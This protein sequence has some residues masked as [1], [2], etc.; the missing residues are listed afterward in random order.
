[1][2]MSTLLIE[3]MQP[4]DWPAVRSIYLEGIAT[5]HATFETEAPSWEDWD[6]SHHRFGRLV[7]RE[8]EGV[9]GWAALTLVSRRQVYA[10]VAEVSVY[11]AGDSRGKGVGSALLKR[12]ICESEQNGIWTLQASVFPEN[13]ATIGLHRACGFREVGRRERIGKLRGVWRDTLLLERRSRVAGI[14]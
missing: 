6:A 3:A 10:G 7:A 14:D 4:N 11:V 1:M 2:P 8:A 12:L 5:N 9:C 13:A